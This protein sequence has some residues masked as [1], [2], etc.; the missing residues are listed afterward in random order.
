MTMKNKTL[1]AIAG[2]MLSSAV[3]AAG[4]PATSETGATG[5]AAS[6][7]APTARATKQ[8]RVNWYNTPGWKLMTPDEQKT[9][10]NT[11]HGF[12]SFD[13]CQSFV[14]EH[15]KQMQDRAKA[16]GQTISAEPQTVCNRLKKKK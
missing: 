12:K 2:L 1:I 10:R 8:A 15:H 16:S 5:Q 3:W 6:A 11:V 13:E 7:S 14:D 4:A 9:F